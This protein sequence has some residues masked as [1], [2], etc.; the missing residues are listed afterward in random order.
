M[1]VVRVVEFHDHE[2]PCM[3]RLVRH[4]EIAVG[5]N[6]GPSSG[7]GRIPVRRELTC[8]AKRHNHSIPAIVR[9]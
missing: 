4:F 6:T 2:V 5:W 7:K 9:R 3:I 8:P 1:T